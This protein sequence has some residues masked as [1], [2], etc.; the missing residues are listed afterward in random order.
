MDSRSIIFISSIFLDIFGIFLTEWSSK[1]SKNY[2]SQKFFAHFVVVLFF[3]SHTHLR[4]AFLAYLVGGKLSLLS[5]WEILR[6][7][8]SHHGSWNHQAA[9]QMQRGDGKFHIN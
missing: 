7:F 4:F 5:T 8:D 2:L 6:Y 1:Y 3:N 9:L